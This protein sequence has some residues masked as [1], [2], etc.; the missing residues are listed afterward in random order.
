MNYIVITSINSVTEAIERYSRIQDWH[1]LVVGDLKSTTYA[2][3]NTT[4]L[5]IEQQHK[6]PYKSLNTTPYKHYSRKNIG[7]LYAIEKGAGL[8]FDTDDDTIPYN[9]TLSKDFTCETTV[10]G[11]KSINP[12]TLYTNDRVWPRGYDLSMLDCVSK[13]TQSNVI[14]KVGVWQGVIDSDTDVDAI[15]RLANNKHIQFD[16]NPDICIDYNCFAPFNTQSTLWSDKFYSLLYIPSSVDFRFTDI[17]RGYVAQRIMWDYGYKIGFHAP[18][19]YQVRN[20]HN[21]YHD[22]LG[23][24][25]MYRCVPALLD[26]LRDMKF[27]NKSTEMD[28]LDCYKR[29]SI[30]GIVD[31]TELQNLQNWIYDI[32]YIKGKND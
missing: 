8:I 18:N 28:L 12:Y 16:A 2:H 25:T 17:L 19:T 13:Y 32:N 15:Y 10:G 1:V 20:A 4:F 6:L 21:Y 5:N 7:Y 29:L 14:S 24:L 27:K 22:L 26:A 9:N 30:A 23:E 3:Y 11:S 31:E